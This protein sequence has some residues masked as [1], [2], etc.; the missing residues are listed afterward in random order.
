MG[1]VTAWKF[2]RA[3]KVAIS[4]GLLA[5]CASL[6]LHQYYKSTVTILPS[7]PKAGSGSLASAA[8]AL[9]LGV[10]TSDDISYLEVLQSRWLAERLLVAPR[11]F[12]MGWGRFGKPKPYRQ[13]LLNYLNDPNMDKAMEFLPKLYS[14]EQDL[15]SGVISINVETRSPQLSQ[16]V[17][18]QA[19]Q[20]LIEFV[21]TQQRTKG[22]AKARFVRQRVQDVEA[23]I[24]RTEDTLRQFLQAN[25]NY[26]TTTDPEVRLKGARL[27]F[28][29]QTKRQILIGLNVSLEQALQQEKDD[30]PLVNI[31]DTGN[32]PIEKSRPGRAI[33]VLLVTAVAG[34][35][36]GTWD[37]RPELR[38]WLTRNPV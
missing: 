35:A 37:N 23:D 11:E 34:I 3:I 1:I 31:L 12:K 16:Q 7:T 14:Q 26:Q 33:I 17:A 25:R 4:A 28:E 27:E 2:K 36:M 15:K 8:S 22:G 29:L 18:Q 21:T 30:T 5:A 32:L 20:L 38:A 6:F 24:S 9:G 10:S 19:A 13:S